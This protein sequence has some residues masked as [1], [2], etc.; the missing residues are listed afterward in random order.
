MKITI[1]DVLVHAG[2]PPENNPYRGFRT[3]YRSG[4][5]RVAA[6]QAFKNETDTSGFT[7][8]YAPA[9]GGA[10]QLTTPTGIDWSGLRPE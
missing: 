7:F 5:V 4:D 9:A 10:R 6:L 3:T 1:G 2:M 8:W